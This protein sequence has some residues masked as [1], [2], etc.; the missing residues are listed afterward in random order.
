MIARAFLALFLFASSFA[1]TERA[2]LAGPEIALPAGDVI[3][4][5]HY[6]AVFGFDEVRAAAVQTLVRHGELSAVPTLAL[7]LRLRRDG[8][9]SYRAAIETLTGQA[10]EDWFDAGLWI[11]DHPEVA[12]HPAFHAIKLEIFTRIDPEFLR[13]LGGERGKQENLKI[14][15][16]EI[17]WGG[18]PVDGIPPL[19]NPPMIDAA[20]A[21]YLQDDDLVFGIAINGDLRAYPLRILGWHEMFNDVIGGVP[22]ALAYCTL[23]GAGI[24]FETQVAGRDEPFILSSSGFLYRSNKLMYDRQT[25]SLWNQFTGEP[26]SGPLVDSGIA[27]KI[28]PVTIAR[29]ADWRSQNPAT[30]V[31]DLDTGFRRDYGSGVVYQRYFASPDLMFPARVRDE[32]R[33]KRKDFVFGLRE[34]GQAKAWPLEAF[35]GGAVIND[36]LGDRNV[37]LIGDADSRS[38]RAYRRGAEAFRAGADPATLASGAGDWQIRED[39]LVGPGGERRARLPGHVAYW[40]AWENYFGGATLSRR[41][42]T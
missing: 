25:D 27:L 5:A 3:S 36:M 23:C 37:V 31:L 8:H 20:E 10:M 38:V 41:G 15:F 26:V 7:A 9:L 6:N 16:E 22:V 12:P 4:I 21:D 19:D 13:F 32:T 17:Y 30:T 11:E 18:V 28:R 35:A 34:F 39:A 29:W 33:V 2:A 1:A 24:L 42:A 14:R 40:F